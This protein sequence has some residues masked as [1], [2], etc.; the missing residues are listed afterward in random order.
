MVLFIAEHH[1]YIYKNL[2][3]E[4]KKTLNKKAQDEIIRHIK[5]IYKDIVLKFEPDLILHELVM[6]NKFYTYEEFKKSVEN[7]ERINYYYNSRTNKEAVFLDY[8][9][10]LRCK[11]AVAGL[12]DLA[13]LEHKSS[14]E[15]Y[16]NKLR[17]KTMLANI[18][19]YIKQGY[20]KIVVN[21]GMDHIQYKTVLN[22][23][24]N[25]NSDVFVVMPDGKKYDKHKPGNYF[26]RIFK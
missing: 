11:C 24:L 21:V 4:Y 18:E 19:K 12:E 17:E 6:P 16:V 1:G 26:K 5:G 25:K 13:I 7:K 2:P 20:E 14:D 10:I 15:E 9:G 23:Y 22:D 8:E 3:L